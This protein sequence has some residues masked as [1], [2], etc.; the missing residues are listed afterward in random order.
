MQD[1]DRHVRHD[2]EGLAAYV[3]GRLDGP[4]RSRV[5]AHLSRC[6][7]CREHLALLA[8]GLS[9]APPAFHGRRWLPVAASLLIALA[10]SGVYLLVRPALLLAP[11][12]TPAQ[13]PP[14]SPSLPAP[15]APPA[16]PP[17]PLP[18]PSRPA[19]PADAPRSLSSRR[20]AGKTFRLL[21]GEWIDDSYDP[22]AALPVIAIGT[23]ADRDAAVSMTPSLRPYEMLGRRFTVVVAGSVYRVDIR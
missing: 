7:E 21:A 13:S 17:A 16:P 1:N 20:V 4:A 6:R 2:T 19:A 14:S 22:L 3:D 10:G 18:A 11:A 23:A 9:A 12:A 5:T 8:H 15:V